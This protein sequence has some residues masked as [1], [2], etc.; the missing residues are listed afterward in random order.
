[1]T[2]DDAGEVKVWD[3]QTKQ[4]LYTFD[5]GHTENVTAV[6]FHPDLPIIFSAGEDDIIN[7]W[8]AFTYRQ[9]QQLNYGLHRVWALHALPSS[10]NVAIGFDEA[11]VVIKIGNEVP[12]VDYSNGKVVL[13]NKREIQTVNLKLS[14]GEFKDGEVIKTN[15]K[16]L[17]RCETFAQSMRFSPSGRYFSVCGDTDFIVYQYPKFTSAAFGN[18]ADLVWATVNQG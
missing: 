12:M 7:I 18:G 5:N 14:Q 10:N 2:G 8:N 9:E 3:Y 4:C 1:M 11:T 15:M 17:G 13:I 6:S 16:D